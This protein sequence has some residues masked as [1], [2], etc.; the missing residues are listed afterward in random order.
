MIKK[1]YSRKNENNV[2]MRVK[3]LHIIDRIKLLFEGYS[4]FFSPVMYKSFEKG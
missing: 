1:W 3:P 2:I 4:G